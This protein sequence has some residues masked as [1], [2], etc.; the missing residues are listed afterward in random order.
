MLCPNCG[1][2]LQEGNKFCPNCGLNVSGYS[3]VNTYQGNYQGYQQSVE[4]SASVGLAIL[5]FFIPLAG[6]IVFLVN[7]E[8]RPKTAKVSGICALVSAILSII[9]TFGVFAMAFSLTKDIIDIVGDDVSYEV[10]IGD[11]E[12]SVNGSNNDNGDV[13]VDTDD[14]KKD[15]SEGLVD[16]EEGTD[17]SNEVVEGDKSNE[18]VND[19]KVDSDWTKYEFVVNG[20]TLTL[21]CTYADLKEA[22]G[23]SMKSSDEKSY[24]EGEYYTNLNLYNSDESIVLNIDILNTSEEDKLYTECPVVRVSQCEYD[25]ENTDTVITFPGGLYVGQEVTKDDLVAIFGEYDDDYYYD[26]DSDYQLYEYTW[27]E[28]TDWTTYNYIKVEILNGVISNITINN[29]DFN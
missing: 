1:T 12:Q 6:L 5:S 3:Q 21:P 17:E 15:S 7:K 2:E 28:D 27:V 29:K 4:E 18:K 11:Y 26:G 23:F 9:I 14:Y 10:G 16:S 20:K 13:I 8:K 24:L 22:T 19:A 25:L